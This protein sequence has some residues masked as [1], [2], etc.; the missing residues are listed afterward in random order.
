MLEVRS[1]PDS[2]STRSGRRCAVFVRRTRRS[3]IGQ[4]I[5]HLSNSVV[6]YVITVADDA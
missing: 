6:L 1:G 3:R 5:E 4:R 2:V